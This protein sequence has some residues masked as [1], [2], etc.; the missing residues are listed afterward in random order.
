[1]D[2]PTEAV[3]QLCRQRV[4]DLDGFR[5]WS[6]NAVLEIGDVLLQAGRAPFDAPEELLA[7]PSLLGLGP[8][9]ELLAGERQAPPGEQDVWLVSH[10]LAYVAVYLI[11]K[12]DGTWVVD[13]D[14][15]SPTFGRYLVS[16]AAPDTG[17]RVLIDP[18]EEAVQFLDEPAG[19]SLLLRVVD[20][21]KRIVTA[22]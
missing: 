18:A 10:V 20:I 6:R 12:F 9:D 19:R 1:M 21:E 7:E 15:S 2:E 5:D 22:E 4:E 3:R 17:A 14:P 13:E 16:V 11:A 8:L